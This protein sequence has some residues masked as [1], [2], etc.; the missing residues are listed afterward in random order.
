MEFRLADLFNEVLTIKM[1]N[2]PRIIDHA[3][4]KKKV[5]IAL[6]FLEKVNAIRKLIVS[7]SVK[8]LTFWLTCR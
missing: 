4:G 1:L 3:G 2:T 5:S 8:Y 7:Q 6:L